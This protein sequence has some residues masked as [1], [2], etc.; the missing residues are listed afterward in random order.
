MSIK[1]TKNEN[2]EDVISLTINTDIL[3]DFYCFAPASAPT[4]IKSMLLEV[5]GN[6]ID[7]LVMGMKPIHIDEQD[8]SGQLNS[9]VVTVNK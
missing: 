6:E 8:L 5:L 4:E 7:R 9:V 2:G 3:N 1:T